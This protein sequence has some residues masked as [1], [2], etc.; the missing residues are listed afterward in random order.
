MSIG[1]LV[2]EAETDAAWQMYPGETGEIVARA[3]EEMGLPGCGR[4]WMVRFG[5]EN[6]VFLDVDLVVVS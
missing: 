2:T 3:D 6:M 5:S 4:F 1:T